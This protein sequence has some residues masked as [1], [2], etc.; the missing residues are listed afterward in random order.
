[1]MLL[2]NNA[3][4]PQSNR[5]GKRDEQYG[6]D[7]KERGRQFAILKYKCIDLDIG[8]HRA[9]N[10]RSILH[11]LLLYL[12]LIFHCYPGFFRDHFQ[13]D[14]QQTALNWTGSGIEL[15]TKHILYPKMFKVTSREV[16]K[17]S[18]KTRE[19]CVS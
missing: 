15:I 6:R 16:I 12:Q 2:H 18:C 13:K 7:K 9:I 3:E 5:G 4:I 14:S 10:E 19:E 17:N 8:I 11:P 1:M